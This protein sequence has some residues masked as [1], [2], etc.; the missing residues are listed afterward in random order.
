[1][2]L[3]HEVKRELGLFLTQ[4]SSLPI[5]PGD[6]QGPPKLHGATLTF[7]MCL[8]LLTLSSNRSELTIPLCPRRTRQVLELECRRCGRFRCDGF[9]PFEGEALVRCKGH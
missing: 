8:V 1:M 6:P 5:D 3:F 4:D 7:E 2:L 9:L